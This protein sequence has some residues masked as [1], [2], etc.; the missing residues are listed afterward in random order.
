MEELDLE[1]LLSWAPESFVAFQASKATLPITD[2]EGFEDHVF[3]TLD[4]GLSIVLVT[5]IPCTG[6]CV[7]RSTISSISLEWRRV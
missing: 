5:T 3:A 6:R 1:N 4:R 2:P 7:H